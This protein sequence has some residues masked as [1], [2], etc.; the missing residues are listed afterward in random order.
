MDGMTKNTLLTMETYLLDAL[1]MQ[2]L[3]EEE[4]YK[5]LINLSWDYLIDFD[6]EKTDELLNF[7]PKK[8]FQFLKIKYFYEEEFMKNL[9]EIEVYLNMKEKVS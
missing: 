6:L 9:H 3:P 2:S 4:I 7:I 8:F 1:K 5:H